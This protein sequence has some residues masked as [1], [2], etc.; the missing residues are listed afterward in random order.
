[1]P[2]AAWS[3]LLTCLRGDFHGSAG[4]RSMVQRDQPWRSLLTIAEALR[5]TAKY[6]SDICD[7]VPGTSSGGARTSDRGVRNRSRGALPKCHCSISGASGKSRTKFVA[8]RK[9]VK[10]RVLARK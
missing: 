3:S 10:T 7:L 2:I 9:R 5:I 6:Y 8:A 4:L 1:M